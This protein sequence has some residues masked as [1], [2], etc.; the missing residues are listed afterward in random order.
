MAA[1]FPA[2]YLTT[3]S[4]FLVR[5]SLMTIKD[6]SLAETSFSWYSLCITW[7]SQM[8]QLSQ[9]SLTKC[10]QQLTPAPLLWS[11]FGLKYFY[12]SF[13]G[14][15]IF[16]LLGSPGGKKNHQKED[17]RSFPRYKEF[18]T[19][20]HHSQSSSSPDKLLNIKTS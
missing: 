16:H 14:E 2:V 5:S 11:K 17:L 20:K 18:S 7:M 1:F 8:V 10:A 19:L 12:V 9:R 6:L 15:E 4:F 3:E 13:H